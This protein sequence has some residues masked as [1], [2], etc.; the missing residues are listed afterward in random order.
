MKRLSLLL[1]LCLLATMI[2]VPALAQDQVTIRFCTYSDEL[3]MV[4]VNEL[5]ADFM[6][7]NPGVIVEVEHIAQSAHYDKKLAE[8][9]S[10]MLP[11]V[12]E[13][14]PGAGSFWIERGLLLDIA[15][16]VAAD[17]NTNLD[18]FDQSMVNYYRKGDA[19]Y[20]LPYDS[21]GVCLYYNK[22]LLD[23]AGLPY[24][25]DTWTYEDLHQSM[26]A[27]QKTL[28]D[29]GTEVWG[30]SSPI[31]GGW[32]GVGYF[33]MMGTPLVNAEGQMG[34]NDT[35]TVAGLTFWLQMMKDGCMPEPEPANPANVITLG[36]TTFLNGNAMFHLG[37]TAVALFD[38]AGINYGVA[39]AP[40][41][42][43][44]VRGAKL[45]GGFAITGDTKYPEEAYK[46]LTFFT[47]EDAMRRFVG[48]AGI[49]T[50]LALHEKLEGTYKDVAHN[51]NDAGYTWLNA[52]EGC[53]QIWTLKDTLLQQ[54]WIGMLTPEEVV[55]ELIYE[56]TEILDIASE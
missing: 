1:V 13:L 23:A 33:D 15:P 26:L 24:P 8:T 38:P 19:L 36:A 55:K 30:L 37:G 22:D 31:S 9:A 43:T 7:Q 20:G 39:P 11:D 4:V 51:I 52:V 28:A 42:P 17:E 45:G 5:V 46:F 25:D 44:G 16:Y 50:R 48:G 47:S 56:G 35:E 12:W 14:V 34:V 29:A 6:A 2:G 18:E 40:L 53:S 3:R 21:N 32:S 41:G 54:M 27:G 49:P 10:G